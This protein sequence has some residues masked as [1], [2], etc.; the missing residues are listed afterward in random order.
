[1]NKPIKIIF[2]NSILIFF[3]ILVFELTLGHW[4]EKDH[5]GYNMRG[6]RLQMINFSIDKEIKKENKFVSYD[7]AKKFYTNLN[8][9]ENEVL[10]NYKNNLQR[11]K[12]ILNE[13]NITP[14]F[15][16]QVRY[17]GNGERILFYINEELKI[18]SLL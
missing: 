4:L 10:T 14:I 12:K 7:E 5:F 18:F 1:M 15:I 9:V 2:I 11:L 13:K 17:D 16:T 3:I 6:K 8:E